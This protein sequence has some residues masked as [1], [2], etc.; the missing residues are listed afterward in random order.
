MVNESIDRRS[1][2]FDALASM[3]VRGKRIV[4]DGFAFV[5]VALG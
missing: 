4:I 3:R 2:V 5:A 1:F